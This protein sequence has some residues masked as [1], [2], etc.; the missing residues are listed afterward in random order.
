MLLAVDLRIHFGVLF[1]KAAAPAMLCVSKP[2]SCSYGSLN[3]SKHIS[4]QES[5]F[6]CNLTA[7]LIV[8]SI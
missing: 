1:M 8:N 3:H 7:S 6:I 4:L 5:I 2:E